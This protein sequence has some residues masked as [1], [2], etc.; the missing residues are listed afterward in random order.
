MDN[1]EIGRIQNL[2]SEIRNLKLD[3]DRPAVMGSNQKF[4]ISDLRFWIRPISQFRILT[5]AP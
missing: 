1:F 5:P 3:W 2:K 4:Q